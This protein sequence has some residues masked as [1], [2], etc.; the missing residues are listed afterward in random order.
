MVRPRVCLSFFSSSKHPSHLPVSLFQNV[1]G[2]AHGG[3]ERMANGS[4]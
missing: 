2:V 4:R 3:E 1:K